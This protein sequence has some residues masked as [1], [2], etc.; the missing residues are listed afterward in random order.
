MCFDSLELDQLL[1]TPVMH[2]LQCNMVSYREKWNYSDP[3]CRVSCMQQRLCTGR[4]AGVQCAWSLHHS[5]CPIAM[6]AT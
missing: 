3:S 6:C 4:D 5:T 1:A 2:Q